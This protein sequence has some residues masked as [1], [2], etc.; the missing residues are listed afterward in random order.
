[1]SDVLSITVNTP[2]AVK[3]RKIFKSLNFVW[4]VIFNFWDD[5]LR[6]R[7]CWTVSGIRAV[8]PLGVLAA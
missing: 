2:I 8:A 7:A 4:R 3:E 5:L 1:M 6:S